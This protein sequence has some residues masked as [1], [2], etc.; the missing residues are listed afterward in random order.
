MADP[1]GGSGLLDANGGDSDATGDIETPP[2]AP[3]GRRNTLRS[4]FNLAAGAIRRQ[5]MAPGL[6]SLGGGSD[7]G[8]GS[9]RNHSLGSVRF[10]GP[11]PPTRRLTPPWAIRTADATKRQSM[12]SLV[13]QAT[14]D[15]EDSEHRTNPAAS[16]PPPEVEMASRNGERESNSPPP[17]SCGI[18]ICVDGVTTPS[19]ASL[20]GASGRTVN[21][22]EPE[23]SRF[24]LVSLP[25]A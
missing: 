6:P 2:I 7:G 1:G 19:D 4:V 10:Y 24:C 23:V 15:E 22:K 13:E 18:Q 3:G 16:L 5:S 11:N 20:L 14:V 8:G 21:S 9:K 25:H 17:S 12:F